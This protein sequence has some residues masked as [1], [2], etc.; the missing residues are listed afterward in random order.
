MVGAASG[1]RRRFMKT[2]I[3][4]K[5][6]IVGIVFSTVILVGFFLTL[7]WYV[8][9]DGTTLRISFSGGA[10]WVNL[11]TIP[12]ITGV[13]TIPYI[14][15]E[16]WVWGSIRDPLR[17]II[18]VPRI[19]S[20]GTLRATVGGKTVSINNSLVSVRVPL[21]I[22]FLAIM[23]PSLIAWWFSRSRFPPGFC[24]QCGYNLTGNT[25]GICSECGTEINEYPQIQA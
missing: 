23:V 14:P 9:Y 1:T 13:G 5:S 4:Y 15:G 17:F 22:P 11:G 19:S 7:R 25:S 21:W 2:S 8:A 10:C 3:I 12:N 20:G 16:G 24:Q 18:W 6:S